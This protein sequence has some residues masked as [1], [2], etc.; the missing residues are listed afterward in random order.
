MPDLR[1]LHY[2]V[3]C[4]RVG[5]L[6]PGEA[7]LL[8]EALDALEEMTTTVD[9]VCACKTGGIPVLRMCPVPCAECGTHMKTTGGGS[10]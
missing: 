9:T 3:S 2:L 4:A 10:D 8:D 7:Q 6:L 5:S 1:H